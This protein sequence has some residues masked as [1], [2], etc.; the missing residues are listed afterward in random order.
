MPINLDDSGGDNGP[1]KSQ[2]N[3]S[4]TLWTI[5]HLTLGDW[6][7]VMLYHDMMMRVDM[8]VIPW[9]TMAAY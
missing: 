1:W 5:H 4:M 6:W 7:S 3:C 9:T 2:N 8:Y